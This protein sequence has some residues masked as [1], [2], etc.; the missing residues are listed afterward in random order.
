MRV[1]D[2]N[3]LK[4]DENIRFNDV[5]E[6]IRGE[7]NEIVEFV[8]APHVQNINW[9][10]G[11]IASRNKY[12]S[13]LFV[14]LCS[15]A[16]IKNEIER[17]EQINSI[18]LSDRPLAQTLKKHFARQRRKIKVHCTESMAARL[19]RVM[20]PARQYLIA[21]ALLSLRYF[22]RSKKAVKYNLR[23]API[24]LIDTFVLNNKAGD[25]GSL[26][27]GV[28]KDR[29]YPGLLENLNEEEKKHIF[30]LPTIIGF[31]NPIKIFK[32]IREAQTQFLVHDDF[33]KLS[34]YLAV[35][36]QPF[37]VRRCQMAQIFFRD[38]PITPLL[39][40]ENKRNC[41]DFISLLGILYYRFA[42]RLKEA[43]V[44]V[45]LL[46]EWYENQVIDRGMIVGFHQFH[47]DT[48]VI[49][50]QGYIIAKSLHLYTCPN[51]SEW[52]G[53]AV[54]DV[55]SVVGEGLR[56]DL[57]E[58]CQAVNVEVAPG[59]RFQK[60]W[61]ERISSPDE[62]FYTILVGLPINLADA[63]HILQLL[64]QGLPKLTD[65]KIRFW[66]KP[67]PTW[68]PEQ[69]MRLLP[70][71]PAAFQFKIGDFHDAIE[72]ANLLIGNASSVCLEA[73]AKGVPVI[74]IGA[75]SGVN[76][77]PIPATVSK[78]VWS[79]VNTSED[80]LREIKKYQ[81]LDAATHL[82][83]MG[84]ALREKFFAPVNRQS[85]LRFLA[86]REEQRV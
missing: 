14:R 62:N 76:Q 17:D 58:F 41:S 67:H 86:L 3:N 8:S 12:T 81:Q 63:E 40:Q 20:R 50:Y 22:A 31:K 54:P 29:Y 32:Q 27:N 83:E 9:I 68:T 25:E 24:T 19:W 82:P 36:A 72:G 57:F 44:K 47:P 79:L 2:L 5:A 7:Y 10:V 61:R 71:W 1:L 60:L 70:E 4:R 48:K 13:L 84:L 65:E 78:A 45:R 38:I 46:V 21:L 43:K 75:H 33:L 64:A 74:V 51:Q 80:C 37:R 85:V 55:I 16:F 28:Y 69:I 15:L 18:V 59:F 11:S 39:R 53:K 52:L 23:Q 34:D 42:Y 30:F 35:L 26:T 73:L 77:N 56:A 66:V 6:K 49:G